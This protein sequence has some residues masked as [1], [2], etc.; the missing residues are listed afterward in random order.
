MLS[1]CLFIRLAGHPV[2]AHIRLPAGGVDPPAGDPPLLI[3]QQRHYG[4]HDGG[5]GVSDNEHD[6]LPAG[7]VGQCWPM[8]ASVTPGGHTTTSF[9]AT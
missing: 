7:G 6:G 9:V 1:R 5:Q 4:R 8:L 2:P 3:H